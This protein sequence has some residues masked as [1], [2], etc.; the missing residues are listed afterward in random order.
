MPP[1]NLVSELDAH[2]RGQK[3]LALGKLVTD[4]RHGA[5]IPCGTFVVMA[6]GDR[7]LRAKILDKDVPHRGFSVP[8]PLN[9]LAADSKITPRYLLWL[10]A[11]PFVGEHLLFHATGSVFL[12]VPKRVLHKLLIPVPKDAT[13]LEKA[14]EVVLE[15]K[16]DEFRDQLG[17]FYDDYVLNVRN[18]RYHTAIILAGA[19]AEMIIYQSLIDQGVERKLLAEDRNL[20][21]GKMLTYLRPLKLDK[22]VPFTHLRDLQKKR[23]AAV[24]AGLLAGSKTRFG[25]SDLGS[26]DHII[27]HYGI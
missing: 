9:K 13:R 7:K 24:H 10:F 5:T 21:L 20:G 4:I 23:N 26:F 27:K 19:M 14:K 22:A 8:L 25:K 16:H 2:F 15:R 3:R 11:Q 1:V 18:E 6:S 12:R 17:A